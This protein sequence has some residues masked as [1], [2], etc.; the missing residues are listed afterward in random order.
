MLIRFHKIDGIIRIY[1]KTRYLILFGT[2]KY[3]AVYSKTRY[4]ISITSGITYI[5]SHYFAKIKV[6]SCDSLPIEKTLTL[7]NVVIH[8]KSVLNKDK[9]RY[10]YKIVL[11][12]C[13]YQ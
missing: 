6:D 10:Y 3:D 13:L 9:N 4:L 1:D 7:H 12:K 2:K 5:I 11:E 8:I